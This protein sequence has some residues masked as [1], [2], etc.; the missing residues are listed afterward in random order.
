MEIFTYKCD[1]GLKFETT[2]VNPQCPECG[3]TVELFSVRFEED[4]YE[5][6]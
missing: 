4:E 2:E 3:N 6:L 5:Y 1:C